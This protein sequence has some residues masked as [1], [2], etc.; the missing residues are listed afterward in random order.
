MRSGK[1]EEASS[2]GLVGH[3]PASY[4]ICLLQLQHF[5]L[6]PTLMPAYACQLETF[7]APKSGKFDWCSMHLRNLVK[8]GK[9][10]GCGGF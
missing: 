3:L 6:L 9:I 5:F 2:C 10:L 8:Q 4:P 7:F 1:S